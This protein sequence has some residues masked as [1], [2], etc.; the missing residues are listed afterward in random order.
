MGK[1]KPEELLCRMIDAAVLA[2]ESKGVKNCRLSGRSPSD[3]KHQQKPD[4][5]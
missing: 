2:C 1:Q 4:R 3:K 5:S